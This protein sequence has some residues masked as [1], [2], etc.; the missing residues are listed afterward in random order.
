MSR[1]HIQRLH[2]LGSVRNA[3]KVLKQMEE[4]LHSFREGYDTVYYLSKL[5]RDMIG[6]KKQVKRSLQTKHSLMRN[7]FFFHVGCPS[8]W[9]NEM[10]VVVGELTIV[11]DATFKKNQRLH[12]LEIDNT[13][14]MT[15]NRLKI[16]RYKALHATGL[17][18]RQYQYFP[19]IHIVTVNR[20]RVRRF[21]EMCEGLPV[22]VYLYD[23]IK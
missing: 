6:S 12:F 16:E 3:Q 10:K 17:F 23:D 2:R 1:T 5:G 15:E 13:Q 7:D 21:I 18:Q 11:P 9:K 8:Y 20:S 14:T 19:M 4:Y 22:Q